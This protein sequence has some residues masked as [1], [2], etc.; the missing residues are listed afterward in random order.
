MLA[1]VTSKLRTDSPGGLLARPHRARRVMA[2]VATS[3][4]ITTVGAG[5]TPRARADCWD[6]AAN[7]YRLDPL[8]L[9][10]IA[11]VES[12]LDLAAHNVNRNGT[13]DIGLMQINSIHLPRLAKYGVTERRLRED[14]CTSIITGAWILAGFVQQFGYGWEAVGAYNAGTGQARASLRKRYADKVRKR[15][16]ILVAERNRRLAPSDVAFGP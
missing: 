8:L 5:F 15:Y 13:R 7:R 3:L 16:A 10:A 12:N 4:L 2:R 1:S 9:Y 6:V 14:A 11:Q